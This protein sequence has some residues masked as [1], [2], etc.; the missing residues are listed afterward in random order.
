LSI[1]PQPKIGVLVTNLGTPD[2]ATPKALRRY[3]G[4]FLADARVVEAP[5]ALWWLILNG[6]ILRTRPRKSAASYRKIWR[7]EGSPLLAIGQRQRAAIA[8]RL[9]SA[10]G[11]DIPVALGMRYGRPPI[12]NAIRELEAAG[13]NRLLVLPLYP[14]YSASTTASTLDAVGQAMGRRRI[15][16]SLRLLRDYFDEPAYLDAL[17][18]SIR[19]YWAE[20]GRGDRLMLSFH[21]IPKKYARKGDIYPAQCGQTGQA[22]ARRLGLANQEWKTTFQS[23]FGPDRWLKPYTDMTRQAWGEAGVGRVDLVCPGFSAD[24]LETLEE[25]N[26]GNRELFLEAGGDEFHY[27][28][29]LNDRADHIDALTGLIHRELGGWL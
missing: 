9:A 27:I 5:R 20:H 13:C 25:N 11:E 16:P 14:Q 15:V 22:V 24:C 17:A 21:G 19:E 23:R 29:C 12:E 3:L 4:E 18:A 1:T 28:P 7:E 6:I 26:I 8:E 10:T 2:A